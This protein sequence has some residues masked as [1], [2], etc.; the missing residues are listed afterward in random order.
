MRTLRPE[1]NPQDPAE[2]GL[3]IEE[4]LGNIRAQGVDFQWESFEIEIVDRNAKPNAE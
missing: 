3:L 2:I 1:I 4:A